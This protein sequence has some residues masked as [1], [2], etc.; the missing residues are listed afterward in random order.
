MPQHIRITSDNYLKFSAPA[1]AAGFYI[2]ECLGLQRIHSANAYTSKKE[3][4]LLRATVNVSI[5][6]GLR[7]TFP[8]L[9]RIANRVFANAI[10]AE[11]KAGADCQ[12]L[13]AQ[14]RQYLE[15]CTVSEK[16]EV[17]VRAAYRILGP[18]QPSVS[19]LSNRPIQ[20]TT[21]L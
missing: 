5:A 17:F 21:I 13:S 8:E 7:D 1:F 12:E 2:S 9:T 10:A 19:G 3:D 11:W 16:I 18:R 15:N 4:P 20:P 14:L 6:R